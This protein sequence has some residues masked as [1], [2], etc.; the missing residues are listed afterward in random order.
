[1][2]MARKLGP[3]QLVPMRV[4]LMHMLWGFSSRVSG[5]KGIGKPPIS[6]VVIVTLSGVITNVFDTITNAPDVITIL[7][8]VRIDNFTMK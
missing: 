3:S 2:V 7:S 4:Q 6:S 1:M 8:D 5:E